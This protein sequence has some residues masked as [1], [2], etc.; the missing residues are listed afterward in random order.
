MQEKPDLIRPDAA[1]DEYYF[2]GRAD[3]WKEDTRTLPAPAVIKDAMQRNMNNVSFFPDIVSAFKRFPDSVYSRPL[4]PFTPESGNVLSILN[5]VDDVVQEDIV[6]V[7][8]S[9]YVKVRLK[10]GNTVVYESKPIVYK[11]NLLNSVFGY[12]FDRYKTYRTVR[13][14]QSRRVREMVELCEGIMDAMKG[15]AAAW[16]GSDA[17]AGEFNAMQ[18]AAGDDFCLSRNDVIDMG[19]Y[20]KTRY[21]EYTATT[22]RGITVDTAARECVANYINRYGADETAARYFPRMRDNM[23]VYVEWEKQAAIYVN[24]WRGWLRMARR[25][26]ASIGDI[27]T[28]YDSYM[29]KSASGGFDDRFMP[30]ALYRI[31]DRAKVPYS[32]ESFPTDGDVLKWPDRGAKMRLFTVKYKTMDYT[33]TSGASRIYHPGHCDRITFWPDDPSRRQVVTLFRYVPTSPWHDGPVAIYGLVPDQLNSPGSVVCSG[34]FYGALRDAM[35]TYYSGL[36]VDDQRYVS[37]DE[38]PAVLENELLKFVKKSLPA[39]KN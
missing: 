27:L 17:L 10:V 32:V 37:Y 35:K 13:T 4:A 33:I 15:A 24:D 14:T 23:D 30:D 6:S 21:T 1:A 31:F 7:Y 29:K 22:A 38:N 3:S 8:V 26:G 9:G 20:R 11:D 16:M 19:S 39:L 18:I 36:R 28:T 12:I 34:P 25:A 5:H 2:G